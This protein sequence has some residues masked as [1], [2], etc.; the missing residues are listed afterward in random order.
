MAGIENFNYL[1]MPA[2][3]NARQGREMNALKIDAAK[4]ELGEEERVA[5]TKWM[6]AGAKMGID[7]MNEM[8]KSGEFDL[9]QW[10]T[11]AKSLDGEGQRRGI[12]ESLPPEMYNASP[13]D[14]MTGL[15]NMLQA[16][17]MGL[18][19]QTQP[20]RKMYK[21]ANSYQR[22]GDNNERVNPDLVKEPKSPLVNIKNESPPPA[23]FRYIRDAA[24]NVTHMEP[25]PGGPAE[26][27]ERERIAAE[28]GRANKATR[29]GGLI[30]D[31]VDRIYSRM[32]PQSAGLPDTG[33]AGQIVSNI[34]IVGSSTDAGEIRGIVETIKG[35]LG[36]EALAEMRANSKTGGALGNVSE[37]EVA[38]LQSLAGNLDPSQPKYVLAYN[39][40]RVRNQYMKV[41]HVTGYQMWGAPEAAYK[42][43]YEQ[44]ELAGDFEKKYGYLP[45]GFKEQ[46]EPF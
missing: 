3:E 9:A 34:P 25:I 7:M 40:A 20:E 10:Q 5:N 16:A 31:E 36:F 43:L 22:Y 24:G 21:D 26:A 46:A 35:N 44:P 37:K 11:Y 15:Q 30:V 19:G 6:Y 4:T 42:K 32:G 2:I 33:G 27:A 38:I 1:N 45:P 28:E 39:L 41:V 14:A 12:W 29:Q 13:E 17:Q 8:Q 23:G 18:A